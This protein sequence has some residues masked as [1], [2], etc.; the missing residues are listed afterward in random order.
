[1]QVSLK[2]SKA[3]APTPNHD[4]ICR[5]TFARLLVLGELMRVKPSDVI[6]ALIRHSTAYFVNKHTHKHNLSYKQLCTWPELKN[7]TR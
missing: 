7:Y 2:Y 6:S 1:M 3:E 4:D 5:H